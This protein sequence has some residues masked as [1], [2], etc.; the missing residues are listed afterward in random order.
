MNLG[1]GIRKE[2]PA[3]SEIALNIFCHFVPNVY[4]S[5]F[6]STEDFRVKILINSENH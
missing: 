6:L 1:F 4:A 5:G 3:I 2:F